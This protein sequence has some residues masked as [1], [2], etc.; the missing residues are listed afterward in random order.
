MIASDTPI[1]NGTR[2]CNVGK[3]VV[4][5]PINGEEAEPH[6]RPV[7]KLREGH[8]EL[9]TA[10]DIVRHWYI[11]EDRVRSAV[12]KILEHGS[13][14]DRNDTFDL[15]VEH[16]REPESCPDWDHH[17]ELEDGRQEMY[18]DAV[19]AEVWFSIE[20]LQALNDPRTADTLNALPGDARGYS[21]A[22]LLFAGPPD[23]PPY[24]PRTK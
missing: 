18:R 21:R 11:P 14:E 13:E 20:M 23:Q 15:L 7:C 22:K 8:M 24:P 3:T 12:Q 17:S 10:R 5:S 1:H 9:D 19:D 6:Y 4:S 16:L 2:H